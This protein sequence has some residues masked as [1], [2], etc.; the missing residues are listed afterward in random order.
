LVALTRKLRETEG[1][2]N[3]SKKDLEKHI[4]VINQF[5]DFKAKSMPSETEFPLP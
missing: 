4:T 2:F 1:K 5:E 3:E